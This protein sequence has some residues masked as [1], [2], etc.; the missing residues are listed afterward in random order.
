MSEKKT[1]STG[2]VIWACTCS[3]EHQDKLHGVGNRV[4]N[5]THKGGRCTVCGDE[6]YNG[7]ANAKG[8]R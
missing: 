5:T 2:T 4:H 8:G 3:N 7:A 6:K 1:N